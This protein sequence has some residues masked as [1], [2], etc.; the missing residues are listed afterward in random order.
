MVCGLPTGSL[1]ALPG[2]WLMSI[3]DVANRAEMQG[4]AVRTLPAAWG[5]RLNVSSDPARLVNCPHTSV[6]KP[7]RRVLVFWLGHHS[8]HGGGPACEMDR[9]AETVSHLPG[10]SAR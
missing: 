10:G 5:R 9:L 6:R 2:H 7:H 1:G 3:P 4:S 8:R